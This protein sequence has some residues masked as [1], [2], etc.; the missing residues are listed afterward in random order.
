MAASNWGTDRRVD[1]TLFSPA[2][3]EFDF[4]QAVRVLTLLHEERGQAARPVDAVRFKAVSSLAFPASSIAS[5]E[6]KKGAP[7]SMAVTFLGMTGPEGALPA[8]YTEVAIDRECFGDRSFADFLDIFNHRLVQLFFESW[9]KH[10]FFVSYEQ[11]HRRRQEPDGFT[12]ALFA[13]IGMGTVGLRNRLPLADLGLLHY[14]GLLAQRPHS[15]EALRAIL[16]DY[17]EAPVRIEQ[18]LGRWYALEAD[19][20]CCLGAE[21]PSAQLGN[22]AVAGDAVWSRQS[23]VRIVLG[24]LTIGQFNQFLPDGQRFAKAA[25]LIRW[26]LGSALEFEIQPVLR[27]EEVPGCR[28]SDEG[29]ARL[30][31]SAWMKTE[32]FCFDATEAVFREEEQ[33]RLEA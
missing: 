21:G 4:F 12:S 20:Q 19:E 7:P 26:F 33:V 28:L 3:C 15:A 27:R 17:F 18:F 23:L 16:Q 5:I 10:R 1:E 29:G 6:Q 25:A 8:A 13:L 2:A 11:A 24:P 22:G 9:K 30:G 14:A 32:P 31:W